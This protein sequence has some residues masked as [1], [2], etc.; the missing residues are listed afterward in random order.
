MPGRSFE[1]DSALPA[2]Q[3]IVSMLRESRRVMCFAMNA[4]TIQ[5]SQFPSKF[6]CSA[7]KVSDVE[8]LAK[9]LLGNIIRHTFENDGG[10]FLDIKLQTQT[11]GLSLPLKLSINALWPC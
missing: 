9:K 8:E 10:S 5:H 1:S 2:L 6:S 4:A 7:L 3:P 11:I